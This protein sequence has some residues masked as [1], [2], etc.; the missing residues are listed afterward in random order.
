MS[1]DLATFAAW[2]LRISARAASLGSGISTLRSRRP[3]RSSAG[4]RTSGLL[5]AI[6]IFTCPTASKPSS[7]DSSSM[8][9]RWISQSAEVPSE[10]RRPPMA[11][12]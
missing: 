7:C 4:S 6:I 11:S 2:I 10:K 9:V 8:S 12:I 1:P 3:G 5:V